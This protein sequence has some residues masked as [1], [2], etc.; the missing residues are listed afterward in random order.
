[1]K[2]YT[3]IEQ[4]KKLAGFLPPILL[5]SADMYYSD[6]PVREWIDK[7]DTSKGTHVVFKSEIFAIENLRN[8]EIGE[9]DVPAWSLAALF[10]IVRQELFD[11]EYIINITEGAND[12]WII[13][14]D[15]P[16]D[17]SSYLSVSG[18]NLIDCCVEMIIKL[19]ERNLL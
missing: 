13:S 8:H 16:Y 7:T 6:V 17:I 4:S 2:S 10:S 12:K 19:K 5:K 14:Y 3:D 15:P 1:M 18:D 11:G 9:D